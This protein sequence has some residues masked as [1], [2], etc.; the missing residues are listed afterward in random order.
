VVDLAN[1]LGSAAIIILL[2]M[3]AFYRSVR[4]GLICVLPNALPLLFTAAMLVWTGYALNIAAV[5]AFTVCLGIVVD[6]TIHFLSRF[7]YELKSTDDV[8]EAVRRSFL[9]VGAAM[10]TTTIVLVCGFA[11]VLAS[12]MP[13]HRIFAGMAV[14]SIGTAILGD[15][16]LLPAMLAA[17]YRPKKGP[18]AERQST[19]G[20]EPVHTVAPP[21]AEPA[22]VL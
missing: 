7:Q 2:V 17:C 9:G 20:T 19:A 11:T 15:L 5:C 3:A 14:S 13:S 18:L 21:T 10:V 16:I 12:Q 8:A 6:D 22:G 4:I 1:S